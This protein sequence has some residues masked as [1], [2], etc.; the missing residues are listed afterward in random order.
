MLGVTA[1]QFSGKQKDQFVDLL[2]K[3]FAAESN[4]SIDVQAASPIGPEMA[5]MESRLAQELDRGADGLRRIAFAMHPV[6]KRRLDY[7]AVGRNHILLVD[8]IQTGDVP[9]Y[10]LDLPEFGAV[11]IADRGE[12]PRVYA[13]VKRVQFPT[14]AL[15]QVISVAYTETSIR[16]FPVFDRAK[17]RLAI[18]MAIGEDDAILGQGGVVETAAAA[19]P[20]GNIAAPTVSRFLIAELYGRLANQQLTMNTLLMHPIQYKEILKW[21]QAEAD[22]VTLNK[23]IETGYVGS[24]NNAKLL[25]SNRVRKSKLFALTTPDKFGRLPERKAIE[26]KI[27]D[28]VPHLRYDIT[29]WE[30]VGFG[31][32]N[33]AGVAQATLPVTV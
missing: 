27:F 17:E 18:A 32:F 1:N 11:F 3:Q 16:R 12:P 31:A 14:A 29:G 22:Q 19:G 24:I 26:V 6:L 8:E 21:S 4:D 28:N 23:I 15:V 10:D 7:H 33:T 20:N 30:Q 2:M 5:L 9:F 13:N 25:L